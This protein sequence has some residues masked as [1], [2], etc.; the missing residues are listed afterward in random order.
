MGIWR[1]L[2]P[3]PQSLSSPVQS[4]Q[5][6]SSFP[7]QQEWC[8]RRLVVLLC[9]SSQHLHF[10]ATVAPI[11]RFRRHA[12]IYEAPRLPLPSAPPSHRLT[13]SRLCSNIQKRDEARVSM[14]WE[15]SRT[16]ST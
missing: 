11:D 14:Q 1:G 8:F 4:L 10:A 2:G 3:F 15:D 7:I 5:S 6:S 12:V 13:N 9:L 16:L